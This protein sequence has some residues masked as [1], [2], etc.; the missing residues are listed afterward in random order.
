MDFNLSTKRVM[1]FPSPFPI[2]NIVFVAH[3]KFD[4]GPKLTVFLR[5][6]F[7]ILNSWLGPSA[8]ILLA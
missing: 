6:L 7:I 2:V 3:K 4:T 1:I 8:R 5:L